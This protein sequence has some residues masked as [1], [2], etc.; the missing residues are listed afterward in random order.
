MN[1][2]SSL[3][4]HSALNPHIPYGSISGLFSPLYYLYDPC[5]CSYHKK[6]LGLLL[7]KVRFSVLIDILVKEKFANLSK[8]FLVLFVFS[9]L[10]FF[11]LFCIFL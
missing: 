11:L 10:H 8:K 6:F 1:D 2:F 9:I 7:G 5:A 3:G 4:T